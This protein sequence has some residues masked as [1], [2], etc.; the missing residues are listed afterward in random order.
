M[1]LPNSLVSNRRNP[2]SIV[3]NG[4]KKNLMNKNTM[5]PGH[6]LRVLSNGSV[7]LS[8]GMILDGK[9]VKAHTDVSNSNSVP[10]K[11]LANDKVLL[12]NGNVV[13]VNNKKADALP[14]NVVDKHIVMSNGDTVSPAVSKH[15][16]RTSEGFSRPKPIA[17]IDPSR[18]NEGFH[19]PSVKVASF[20]TKYPIMQPQLEHLGPAKK[21]R[22][23]ERFCGSPVE[24][25]YDGK[26]SKRRI[27]IREIYEPYANN[28]T[29]NSMMSTEDNCPIAPPSQPLRYCRPAP[30]HSTSGEKYFYVGEAYGSPVAE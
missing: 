25:P 16:P 23:G 24:E 19:A 11:H 6:P 18:S 7:V 15:I 30:F 20:A 14:A 9:V 27:R 10:I 17:V 12:G 28:Q 2:F 3:N 4:I 1:R 22:F 29:M 26:G 8:D 5:D 21:R 13:N